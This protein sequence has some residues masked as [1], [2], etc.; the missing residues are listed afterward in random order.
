[1]IQSR[2]ASLAC[3]SKMAA[4]RIAL[5]CAAERGPGAD[6]G[7]GLGVGWGASAGDVLRFGVFDVLGALG[8]GAVG[9]RAAVPAAMGIASVPVSGLSDITSLLDILAS[10]DLPVHL[11]RFNKN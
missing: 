4:W 9:D 7:A 3:L 8:A 5:A 2:V 6:F 1:M 11:S 10:T